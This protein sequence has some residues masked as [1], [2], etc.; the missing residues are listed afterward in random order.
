M[1]SLTLQYIILALAFAF[2]C[3]YVFRIFKKNFSS[4]K[5]DGK[6]TGCGKDCG[7]S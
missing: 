2:A 4:K 6:K 5:F 1:N 3:Y 7:C